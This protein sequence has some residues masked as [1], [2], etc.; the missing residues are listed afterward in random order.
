L[1]YHEGK[2]SGAAAPRGGCTA[3]LLLAD[4]YGLPSQ[5]VGC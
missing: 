4:A 1:I 5:A 3:R 2:Y